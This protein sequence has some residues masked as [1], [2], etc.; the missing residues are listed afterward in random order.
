MLLT[1]VMLPQL[2][3][4]IGHYHDVEAQYE[5]K[6]VQLNFLLNELLLA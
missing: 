4:L 1:L 5:R 6:A 3:L 2:R